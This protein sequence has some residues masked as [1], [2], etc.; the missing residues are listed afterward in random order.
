MR[1]AHGWSVDCDAGVDVHLVR[2]YVQP[3]ARAVPGKLAR[4]LGI[5]HLTLT[6][7]LGVAASLWRRNGDW[8]E[9]VIATEDIDPHDVGIEVLI[10]LGQALWHEATDGERNAWLE[11]LRKESEAGVTGEI[12][13]YALDEKRSLM[14][15]RA[16][17]R[18]TRRL[19]RYAAESFAR[20]LAEYIHSLWHDV[21]VRTGEE[22]LDADSLARRLQLFER[23]F[24]PG[25][26]YRLFP[27]D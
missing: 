12:D 4:R 21:T 22:H 14:A 10:C 6:L 20:T 24:P 17:A 19:E 25:R 1:L 2:E 15:S 11:L 5:V 27:S 23:W 7:Q 8:L 16:S 18:S 3:A 26:G 13:E 9:I